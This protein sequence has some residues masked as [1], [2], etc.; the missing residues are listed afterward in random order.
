MRLPVKT[1]AACLVAVAFVGQTAMADAPGQP[2]DPNHPGSSVYSYGVT[3]R[4]TTCAGRDVFIYEP[5]GAR[6]GQTF[7]VVIYGHGQALGRDVYDLTFQHLAKKGVVVL[8]P[9][10][11]TGFFDQDWA[12]MA[13]DF[14]TL[15]EC[16]LKSVPTANVAQVV[17]SG[18][19]K[20]A[21]VSSIAAQAAWQMGS[22]VKPKSV[23]LFETAGYMP[24]TAQIDSSVVWTIVTGD[25]DQVVKRSDSEELYSQLPSKYKQ[26]ITIK[27]YP[28]GPT[29]D[30]FWPLT[31]SSFFGGQ[32]PNATHYYGSWKWL[33]AAAEDLSTGGQV[34]N[35]HIYGSETASKGVAGLEDQIQRSW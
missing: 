13:R 19:S 17:F 10:Y 31:K 29:A 21:Y 33:A 2:I 15:S 8:F 7:P 5:S 9:T 23:V 24:S 11:D 4:S 1:L 14:V 25:A 30:H 16:A 20:G 32:G 26:L 34:T 22:I 12:R 35:P 28:S 27:S 18:H 6:S 3:Q